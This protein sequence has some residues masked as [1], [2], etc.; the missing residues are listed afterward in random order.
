[1]QTLINLYRRISPKNRQ[2]I[3]IIPSRFGFMFV[4][5]LLIMLLGAINYSNSMGHLLVFLLVSLGHTAM[6]HTHR[7]IAKIELKHCHAEPV[8]CGQTAIFTVVINN[9]SQR[10][11]HQIEIANQPKA[12][13][14]W[15]P[16]KRL[17][18]FIC[19]NHISHVPGLQSINATV[20]ITT[21]QRGYHSLGKLRFSTHFPLGLF[22]SWTN[23]KTSARVLVY[24]QAAGTLPLPTTSSSGE[25]IM[26]S[27]QKGLDDFA[28]F[29][30]YRMGDSIHSIA[31]KAAA[32]D[33]VLRTKQFSGAHSGRRCLS[34]NDTTGVGDTEQRLSQL[35]QWLLMSEQT[36]TSSRLELPNKTIDYGVGEQHLHNCLTALALYHDA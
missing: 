30:N 31:W 6:L 4:F 12:I 35:C 24:P 23:F 10:D 32:R 17:S 29:H 25:Q 27:Q 18:G 5:F 13:I 26:L 1:M 34:W 15:N 19:K 20:E 36:E 7:N 8:F 9:P 21:Q 28:G 14:S 3:Y 16:F 11:F 33:D 2:R 22:T